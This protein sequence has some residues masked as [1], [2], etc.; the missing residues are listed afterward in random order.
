M[1]ELPVYKITIDDIEDSGIE[2]VSLVEK[3]AIMIKGLAFS[4]NVEPQYFKFNDDKQIIAG[5]AL[6]PDL[7]IYRYD[8]DLGEY[9]VVFE[10][11][12]IEKMVDKFNKTQKEYK[13]N[14]EHTDKLVP[15]FI[16]GSWIIEDMTNDK[17]R[18]Y[19]FTDLPVGTWFIEV[20]I[21]D[22]EF[23]N[24]EVRGKNRT[25]FSIEGIMGLTLSSIKNKFEILQGGVASSNVASYRWN[26]TNNTLILTF[27]DGSRYKYYTID[28]NDFENIILGDA[29][30]ITDGENEYGRWYEGKSPS[31]G[32]AVW[33][34]LID[35]NIRYE[36]MS[37]M[38]FESYD[39]YPKAAQDN[40]CKVLRWRDEHGE[41]EVDGMTR[42]G[43]VRAN[44]LCNGEKISEDTIA[45]M[46]GFQRHKQNSEISDEFKGTPWKDR[47]YVAWL[48]WG[49]TEGIEW[50]S[51]KLQ[52]IRQTLSFAKVSFDV[53]GVID[54]EKGKEMLK[55]AIDNGDEIYI[56]SARQSENNIWD[57]TDKFNIPHSRIF[58]TGSNKSK[59]EKIKELN[60][61]KH[62]DNN[63]DVIKEL[64]NIGLKFINQIKSELKMKTKKLIFRDYT[65]KSG[66][67]ITIDGDMA[68]GSSVFLVKE[69]GT[70]EQAPEGEYILEDGTTLFV[71]AEGYINEVRT[72]ATTETTQNNENLQVTPEEVMAV[73]NPMFEEMRMVIAELQSRIEV[74]EGNGM[75]VV[76]QAEMKQEFK[77]HDK[78][79]NIRTILNK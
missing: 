71:D 61:D 1:K 38:S 36:K 46:S 41:D 25:G 29:T 48:G 74:L 6:I 33:E 58:A 17:S 77:I 65:L 63:P 12:T 69:D 26:S 68:I 56:I 30:C 8:I 44:Q 27:H 5:A 18:M 23:W 70:R 40:A 21:E 51:R 20:K 31:V 54:T 45:R 43:W 9:Y 78:I 19:G 42:V 49:G 50:A 14:L 60:I 75:M 73:V 52:Q 7:K 35:K 22:K 57:I 2:Y 64:G 24:K 32:A 72:A 79:N 28:R 39:D 4:D 47:G 59:I 11:E 66:D 67:K 62:I 10:K 76:E 37:S 34:Y 53:D 15:A 55:Q 13:I 3:P 16:K